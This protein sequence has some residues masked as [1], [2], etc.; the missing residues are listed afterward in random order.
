MTPP[1]ERGAFWR[2]LVTTAGDR[3]VGAA[4]GRT[5]ADFHPG[6]CEMHPHGAEVLR[7]PVDLLFVTPP[8]DTRLRPARDR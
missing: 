6:E 8:H 7:E 4:R 3:V 5:A 2:E 1:S